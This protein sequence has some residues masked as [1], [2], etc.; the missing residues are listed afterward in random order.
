[1]HAP[2]RVIK[3]SILTDLSKIGFIRKRTTTEKLCLLEKG[4]GQSSGEGC[5][6]SAGRDETTQPLTV[7][8]GVLQSSDPTVQTYWSHS[9]GLA[10][11][12]SKMS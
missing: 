6:D 4:G 8:S 2:L 7:S 3:P 9:S 1:M 10:R 5:G 12:V 11:K